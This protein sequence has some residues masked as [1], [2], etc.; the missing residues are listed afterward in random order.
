MPVT[1]PQDCIV[2]VIWKSRYDFVRP[3]LNEV[4]ERISKHVNVLENQVQNTNEDWLELPD[5]QLDSRILQLVEAG[6]SLSAVK[7]LRLRGGYTITE[8]KQFVDELTGH[9]AK[10]NKPVPSADS[11]LSE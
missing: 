6:D 2:R 1:V 10:P 7:L 5:E 3:K 4:L 9:L 11:R 8:A